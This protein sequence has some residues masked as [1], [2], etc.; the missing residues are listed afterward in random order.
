MGKK[1]PF[2]IGYRTAKTA[3]GTGVAIGIA[4]LLQLDFY[5]SAGILTILC[6]SV[7]RKQSFVVSWER[8]KAC[9]IGMAFAI[10]LFEII[11]YHPISIIILMLL[12]IP[13]AVKA[14]AKEGIVTSSV[15]ILHLYTLEMVS[16]AIIVNELLLIII[17]IGVAL[18]MNLYMPSVEK[19]LR[20]YQNVIEVNFKIILK[21]IAKHLQN[22]QHIWD[23]KEVTETYT[24]IQTGKDLAL[25]NIENH[26]LRYEDQYYHYFKMREKQFDIIERILPF[27]SSLDEKVV[28]SDKLALYLERL[29]KGVTPNYRGPKFLEDLQQMRSEFQTMPLPNTREEFETRSALLYIMHELEQYLLIKQSL[30]QQAKGE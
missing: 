27:V 20:N 29:S 9:I 12:F 30:L 1:I 19:D 28:Q 11:G 10:L 15:I 3:I 6:I 4:Q 18:L 16:V 13:V 21:E 17:G 22:E 23:G 5:V 26:V 25:K 8:F 7:T 24:A 2:T 14:K